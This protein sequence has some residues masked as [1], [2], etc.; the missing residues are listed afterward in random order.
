MKKD[1]FISRLLMREGDCPFNQY[2][3]I[4]MNIIING[5]R[6]KVYWILLGDIGAVGK[7]VHRICTILLS[8]L[9]MKKLQEKEKFIIILS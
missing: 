1:G 8:S 6:E 9:S 5:I 4:A 7:S 2:L 3:P